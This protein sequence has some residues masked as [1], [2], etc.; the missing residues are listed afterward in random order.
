LIGLFYFPA[1]AHLNVAQALLGPQTDHWLQNQEARKGGAKHDLLIEMQRGQLAATAVQA[2]SRVRC[3]KVIDA[4]GGCKPTNVFL[5]LPSSADGRAVLA[6]ILDA[7]PGIQI[8]VWQLDAGKRKPRA[9]QCYRKLSEFFTPVPAG[10]YTKAQ[11]RSQA[12]IGPASLD[13]AIQRISKQGSNEQRLLAEV[14]ITYHPKYGRG[15][16]SYFVKA[17]I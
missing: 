8:K 5:P 16:K 10:N 17:Q 2:I 7:M 1:V 12:G 6:A 14:G 15:A 11:V 13:R 4:T 3:R 9:D